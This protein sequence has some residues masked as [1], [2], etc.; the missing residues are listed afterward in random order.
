MSEAYEVR[1]YNLSAQSENKIH[2]DTVARRFGFSGALV[3]GVEVYAYACHPAVRRWGRDWLEH[4][5]A[6]CRFQS[7]V[8]DG[9]LVSVE[10]VQDGAALA[11]TVRRGDTPCATATAALPAPAAL[12]DAAAWAW[13]VPPAERPSASEASLAPGTVLGTAPLEVTP[14]VAAEYLAAVREADPIYAAQGLVHP[15]MVLRLCNQA[16]VQNVV[17]GPWIHVGSAVRNLAAARVGETLTARARVTDNTERKG[18]K[19]VELEVLVVA[20]EAAPVAQVRHTAIWR[21]RQV[22]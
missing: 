2:D 3:P 16:L 11:I 8:Y 20:G 18:H 6:E 22:G 19:I 9:D 1:A 12:P 15:G 10:A 14:A 13:R 17:L 21:P 4:G 5:T 7:P